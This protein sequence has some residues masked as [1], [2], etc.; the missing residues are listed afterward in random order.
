MK[1]TSQIEAEIA[2][3]K[4]MKPT[5]RQFSA[6]GYDSHVAID[7]Q[8][9]TLTRSMGINDVYEAF[10]EEAM[11]DEFLEHELGAAICASVWMFD[12]PADST[13]PSADWQSLVK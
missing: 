12:S 3:L 11:G 7:A 6:L 5:V 8:I 9:E 4:V 2:A 10:G 13:T 1:T